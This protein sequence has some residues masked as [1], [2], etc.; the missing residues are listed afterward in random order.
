MSATVS[1]PLRVKA[2][3][4]SFGRFKDSRERL[5]GIGCWLILSGLEETVKDSL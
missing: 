5:N 1:Y 2:A 3:K 4:I